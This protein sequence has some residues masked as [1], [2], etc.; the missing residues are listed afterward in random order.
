MSM[1]TC[2]HCGMQVP[3]GANVCRGCGAEIVYGATFKECTGG[4]CFITIVLIIVSNFL[5]EAIDDFILSNVGVVGFSIITFIL[6]VLIIVIGGKKLIRFY[7]RR[8]L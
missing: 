3:K 7:R 2:P 8:R 5:P 6:G 4:G 1:M